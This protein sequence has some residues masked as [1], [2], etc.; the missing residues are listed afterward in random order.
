M[1]A[2]CH[3]M[4]CYCCREVHRRRADLAYACYFQTCILQYEN[5]TLLFCCCQFLLFPF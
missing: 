2:L 1:H 3:Y 5:D 4:S